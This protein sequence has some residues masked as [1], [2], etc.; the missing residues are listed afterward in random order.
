M[1][2]AQFPPARRWSLCGE[3]VEQGA[4]WAV[5]RLWKYKPAPKGWTAADE[6]RLRELIYDETMREISDRFDFEG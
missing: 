2:R 3:A 6:E 1:K 5:A 4:R